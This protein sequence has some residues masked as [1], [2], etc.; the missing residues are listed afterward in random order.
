MSD[1]ADEAQRWGIEPGYHDVF[2]KWHPANAETLRLLTDILSRGRAAP[3]EYPPPPQE[4]P[5]RAWQGDGN[6]H[7]LLAVQLYGLRS[8]KNWGI[9]DFGDLKRLIPIAA[10]FGASGV[11]LNPLHALF[12][13]APE[14]ASPYAPNSRL[15]LNPLYIDVEA[16]PEF[17]GLAAARLK[18]KVSQLRKADL[19]DYPTVGAAKMKGLRLAYERFHKEAKPERWQAFEAYRQMMGDALLRFAAFEALREE[20]APKPWTEWPEPWRSGEQGALEEYRC[21]HLTEVEFHEFV[22]WVADEQLEACKAAAQASG[23]P[24]GLYIDLAVGIDPQGADAWS[25]QSTVLNAM[26]VGAPP[27]EFNTGGQDW[28]LAPF[29]PHS[30]G[31]NDFAPFRQLLAAAMRHAGAIR[32]DH[33]LGLKRVYMVPH[34]HEASEG[35]YVRFPFEQLLQVVAEESVK[36]RCSVIGEDLGTVPEGFRDTTAKWGLWSYRVMLFERQDD[37]RFKPPEWYPAEALA[38]F[39]THDLPS[40]AGWMRSYDLDVKHGLDIDPGETHAS[41]QQAQ[42]QLLEALAER[43]EGFAPDELAAVAKYLGATPCKLV[44]IALD[45]ILG[46]P[47]QINIPGTIEEHPNWRRKVPLPLDALGEHVEFKKVADAFAQVGRKGGA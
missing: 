28:G 37:G 8:G 43:G 29:N 30:V 16:I 23:M 44:A 14:R 26:S 20:H 39:N 7:W 6:R 3:A 18:S 33:V 12:P 25:Q 38:T 19:V 34:G 22:Q 36:Y 17:P 9:G 35:V 4:A 40:F 10:Q 42:S 1:L 5:L 46:D 27:D 24:V 13:E 47:E 21:T 31:D 45:D 32:L 11:G 41:R 15:F 2:G